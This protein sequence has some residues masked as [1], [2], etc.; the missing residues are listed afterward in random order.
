MRKG[1]MYF[2]TFIICLLVCAMIST[3][4]YA[5]TR[6]RDVPA[7][8]PYYK[9]VEWAYGKVRITGGYPGTGL[10]GVNDG[11]TRGQV[12]MFLW[13]L[14]GRPAPDMSQNAPYADV[15]A[16]H[17]Y[18]KAILW[19]TQCGI[20]KGYSDGTFGINKTCTRGHIVQFMWNYKGRPAPKGSV[21]PFKDAPTP[22][23]RKSII[24]AAENRITKGFKDGKFHDTNTCTR[25]Q[26][27]QLLYNMANKFGT[28]PKVF[29]IPAPVVVTPPV[30][31][32]NPPQ[33]PTPT[34]TPTEAPDVTP[35]PTPTDTPPE[36]DDPAPEHVHAWEPAIRDVII[37]E[38][39]DET[40]TFPAYDEDIVIE[41]AWTEKVYKEAWDETVYHAEPWDEKVTI[42]VY[43]CTRCGFQTA[44]GSEISYHSVT[45]Q[46][47]GSNY[48]PA[49]V[50]TIVHH[51][52]GTYET[53]HHKAGYE[54]I[55]HPEVV[56]TV[57]H[58]ASTEVVHHDAEVRNETYYVCS[59]GAERDSLD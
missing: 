27:V 7:K 56:E 45:C 28:S 39:W 44:S 22:A 18:Y 30:M 29:V 41:P 48:H 37:T 55:Y 36:G 49:T 43:E 59:C 51:E 14:A 19:G 52:G 53:I 35:T 20:T 11:C 9:S 32:D 12:M 40:V 17:P 33:R 16:S 46:G 54:Y 26:T 47:L 58:E 5:G 24:W 10:F 8:H 13:K 2:R 50:T 4:A 38:E 57:H 31:N 3:S 6:F 34:P 25:G 42:G 21:Y 1:N 23:Y 15:P